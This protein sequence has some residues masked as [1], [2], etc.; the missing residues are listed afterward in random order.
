MHQAIPQRASQQCFTCIYEFKV[1][2]NRVVASASKRNLGQLRIRVLRL[3][4]KNCFP[5]IAIVM[6]Y[7]FF[8]EIV[9]KLG[10]CSQTYLISCLRN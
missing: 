5:V 10:V 3:N 2:G 1:L 4:D 6:I 7:R 8:Y 9:E